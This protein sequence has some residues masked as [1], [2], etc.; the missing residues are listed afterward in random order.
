MADAYNHHVEAFRETEY[1]MLKDS[2]YLDHA[3]TTLYS[4]SLMEK[5]MSDMMSNLYGNPHSASASSQ[6]STTRIEDIRL[7][8]LRFFNADPEEFDLVFVANATAGI[9]LVIEAFRECE[10]GFNYGYHVDAHTSLVGARELAKA[11][12]CMDDEDVENW[13]AGS[14]FLA[15]Q[16]A[17]SRVNLFAYPAQSNMDGRRL[18]L[19]W[20]KR[21]QY[22]PLN[23][24]TYTLLDASSLVSTAQLDLSNA[25]MAPDFT[26]LSFY[27]I[28]GFPDLG[29]LIVRKESGAILTGRKYFGGGTV[30]VVLCN[31]EQ[32]HVPKCESLHESLEDG[33]LPFHNIMALDAAIDTH[34][35]LYGS[36]EQISRHTAFLAHKLYDGLSSLRHLNS[37]PVCTIYSKGFASKSFASMQ[38]PIIAFNLV[39]GNGAWV[40]N[41]E[42]E[43]LAAVR[44]F[45]IRSGGLCNPGGIAACLNLEPWEMRK[46]FSA[47]F[48][49]GAETDIY[50]GKI[51]GVIRASVGA[52]STLKDVES[53]LSFVEEFYVERTVPAA[54]PD[55][56]SRLRSKRLFVES[57]TIYPIKSC[58]GLSIPVNTDWE[59]RPEGLAW[60]REW[61]LVH[62]GT[63]QALSQK[64]HPKM[65]LIRPV[66]NFREGVLDIRY[67]GSTE[68]I[69]VPLSSD[70]KFFGSAGS[71]QPSRVCGDAIVAHTYSKHEVNEFFT[72]ILGVSCALARFPAGGSGLKSRHAKAH[73]QIYQ[74]PRLIS[75]PLHPAGVGP[76]PTPPDSDTEVQKRPILLS[77]ESP[78]LA[79]N[80]ASL[81]ALNEEITKA[82]G[83]LASPSVFRAN[84]VMSPLESGTKEPYS[85]DH[86]TT[87]HIGPQRFQVLGSCRRCHMICVDQDTAQKNEEPFVTLAKTRRFES[88]IFFGSHM[89]HVP[90]KTLTKESQYPTI[91]VGDVVTIGAES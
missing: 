67:Q 38:G 89:C 44:K 91:R 84:I 86:W 88:K 23:T 43:K 32:W 18:P 27:K 58:A 90:S 70:P 20:T 50:S 22:G 52:M 21:A 14:E 60:D 4:K 87:L 28:F 85:E 26:V 8:V 13:L 64:R 12:R 75:S 54:A 69:T 36:M 62:Q 77:N 76:L 74:K 35:K 40:S 19:S 80:R 7:K 45:H 25:S 71:A 37:N 47:G 63:G 65:A 6:L 56:P 51:T 2:V 9:K 29:A 39:N 15:Y 1:P 34:E 66:I 17:D 72:R 24:S 49:C 68:N 57:L 3:G 61:C 79:I 53:F 82:G 55:S 5:Y 31:K 16:T 10:G 11:S 81:D 59:V 46:N 42:F 73:M 83:K 78:I 30:D 33:S 48:K 41:T